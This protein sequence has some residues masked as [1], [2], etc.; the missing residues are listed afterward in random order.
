MTSHA[1]PV[2]L[3]RPV[4]RQPLEGRSLAPE[5]RARSGG[6]PAEVGLE[7]LVNRAAVQTVTAPVPG[8]GGNFEGANAGAGTSK[9]NPICSKAGVTGPQAREGSRPTRRTVRHPRRQLQGQAQVRGR[10]T[11]GRGTSARAHLLKNDDR[12]RDAATT[13]P[14]LADKTTRCRSRGRSQVGSS[15]VRTEAG[16][17]ARASSRARKAGS[18]ARRAVARTEGGAAVPSALLLV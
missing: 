15:R 6:Q 12:G 8:L 18:R 16:A 11:T 13:S 17:R 4:G 14:L 10:S 2:W 5:G 7:T 3:L 1:I 9:T